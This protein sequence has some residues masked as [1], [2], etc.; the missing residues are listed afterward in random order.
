MPQV[1]PYK[2]LKQISEGS[3]GITFLA[4]HVLLK[5]KVCL[6]QERTGRSD[7]RK[8]FREEAEMLWD[9]CHE[10]LPSMKDFIILKHPSG[11]EDWFMAMTFVEGKNIAEVV[12][13]HGFI[14][15]EH[16]AWIVQRTL[17]ALN[18]L[19]YHQ[20]IHSDLKPENIILNIPN[21]NATLVDFGLSTISPTEKS[22][23]KGGTDLYAPPEFYEGLPPLPESDLYALGKTAV[24]MAGGEVGSGCFPSSMHPKLRE[25]FKKLLR[26][27][28]KER[29]CDAGMFN[30]ELVKLRKEIF[31]R[32]S[33][34]EL[35]KTRT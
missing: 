15:D 16:I 30:L 23:A 20:I 35:F 5:K 13:E 34:R 14:D 10:S 8:L 17:G 4:E 26:H 32:S 11:E 6:K 28:P 27:N 33:T 19:H 24:F 12:K 22:A 21:H 25:L 7:I 2:V 3:F 1:G 18:F 29:P 9:L 31:G